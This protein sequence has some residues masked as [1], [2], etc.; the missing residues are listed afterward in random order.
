MPP[1]L[2]LA[3]AAGFLLPCVAAIG[4]G[5]VVDHY[6]KSDAAFS[7]WVFAGMA[8]GF[9]VGAV[10]AAWLIVRIKRRFGQ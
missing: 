1:G 4:I 3:C 10:A 8:A 9:I 5:A 6:E 7:G 2:S